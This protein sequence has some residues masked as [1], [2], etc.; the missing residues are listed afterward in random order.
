MRI[1]ANI[2]TNIHPILHYLDD[3][4]SHPIFE[5]FGFLFGTLSLCISAF[6]LT[7]GHRAAVV[8]LLPHQATAMSRFSDWRKMLQE[9]GEKWKGLAK[10]QGGLID[11]ATNLASTFSRYDRLFRRLVGV[12]MILA[13]LKTLWRGRHQMRCLF[14][15]PN[16]KQLFLGIKFHFKR[17]TYLLKIQELPYDR[18]VLPKQYTSAPTSQDFHLSKPFL[19]HVVARWDVPLDLKMSTGEVATIQL[20][21]PHRVPAEVQATSMFWFEATIS[22]HLGY[23]RWRASLCPPTQEPP[24]P[25]RQP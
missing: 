9:N 23:R 25:P 24:G 22:L 7:R 12:R 6:T 13:T 8:G 3:H 21:D 15:A 19:T 1:R 4:T 14:G 2:P 20:E 5:L 16:H 10:L 18:N 17:G 11:S